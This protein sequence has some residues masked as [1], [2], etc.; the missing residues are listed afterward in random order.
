[1]VDDNNNDN[2]LQGEN[3]MR[4]IM[5]IALQKWPRTQDTWRLVWCLGSLK[6]LSLIFQVL[7]TPFLR[8]IILACLVDISR[9]SQNFSWPSMEAPNKKLVF[10]A[11]IDPWYSNI[12]TSLKVW[13]WSYT[14]TA[15]TGNSKIYSFMNKITYWCWT[16]LCGIGW[17]NLGCNSLHIYKQQCIIWRWHFCTGESR[18]SAVW[19]FLNSQ[20][21]NINLPLY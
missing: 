8:R 1:M 2:E 3:A 21:N 19:Y 13:W 7:M 15:M 6:Q 11:Q 16:C 5:S 14:M 18:K 10:A 12:P 9:R 20:W 4:W 17:L